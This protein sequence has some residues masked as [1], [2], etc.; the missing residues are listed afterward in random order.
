VGATLLKILEALAIG[1]PAVATSK[2]AQRLGV[3]NR[4]NLLVSDDQD[5]FVD[6][7]VRIYSDRNFHGHLATHAAHFVR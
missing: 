6:G 3:Q 4:E 1:V 7:V 5:I 2:R